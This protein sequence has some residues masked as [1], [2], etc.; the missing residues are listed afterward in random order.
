MPVTQHQPHLVEPMKLTVYDELPLTPLPTQRPARLVKKSVS[1]MSTR[2]SISSR[3]RSASRFLNISRPQPTLAVPTTTLRRNP[4]FRPIQLSIY[5]NEKRLSDLPEFDALSFTEDGEIRPPPPAILRTQSMDLLRPRSFVLP[6]AI[7]EKPASMFEQSLSRRMSHVRNNT[8]S[9]ILSLSRPPSEYDALHS[10]P[11]SWYSTPG[12]PPQLQF[13]SPPGLSKKVLSPMKEEFTPPPS[14]AVIINGKILAFPNIEAARVDTEDAHRT[15]LPPAPGQEDDFAAPSPIIDPGPNRRTTIITQHKSK[16]SVAASI[17]LASSA[18]STRT[19]ATT[20]DLPL[21]ATEPMPSI[22]QPADEPRSYFHTDFKTNNR[23]NQWLDSDKVEKTRS[24]DSSIST[25]RTT[26]TTSSF[27]EHRRKRSQF[28]QLN[29]PKEAAT[30]A[31]ATTKAVAPPA[32]LSLH[33][34]IPHQKAV[35]GSAASEQPASRIQNNNLPHHT[36]SRTKSSI[37]LP[38]QGLN[39]S[40]TRTMTDSTIAS[41][42]ATDVLFEQPET[43][44]LGLNDSESR[45]EFHSARLPPSQYVYSPH[46][47]STLASL[48]R[49]EL[50]AESMTTVDMKSRTGTM[51]STV[52]ATSNPR[53]ATPEPQPLYSEREQ[54]PGVEILSVSKSGYSHGQGHGFD[55]ARRLTPS[56][57]ARSTR[58]DR[59]TDSPRTPLSAKEA[60]VEKMVFEM[61]KSSGFRRVNVGMAF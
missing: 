1:R 58:S 13:A 36:H 39:H 9:T 44:E 2:T 48:R 47:N 41:T 14:G 21:T 35:A 7:N 57:A 8:D 46:Q 33:K 49:R 16:I 25:V 11:I 19:R 22:E 45:D 20:M 3:S 52:T 6:G 15:L 59:S 42:I 17:M 28:Y 43:P 38:V 5:M 30:G 4:S 32:P 34:K 51:K 55:F 26:S 53:D 12:V 50:D 37:S 61:C 10:H 31:P 40:H 56:P 29:H 60:D 54:N 23:I 18:N 24:R 27:A